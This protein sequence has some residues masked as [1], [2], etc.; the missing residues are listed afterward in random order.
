MTYSKALIDT[1]NT[2]VQVITGNYSI[3]GYTNDIQTHKHARISHNNHH[4]QHS[5]A[6]TKPDAITTGVLVIK[7]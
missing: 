4:Q 1:H 5:T 6:T 7:Q 3:S 2:T